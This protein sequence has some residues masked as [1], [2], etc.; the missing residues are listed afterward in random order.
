MTLLAT[1]IKAVQLS[2]RY[3]LVTSTST[4]ADN[5]MDFFINAGQTYLDKLTN[6]PE[7]FA[8]LFLPLAVDEYSLTFQHQCRAITDVWA[9]S[10]SGRYLL[11]KVSLNDLKNK[12]SEPITSVT[13]DSVAYYAI[14]N[15]RALETTDKTTLGEFINLTWTETDEKYNYRGL[16]IVP[17]ADEAMTIEI[18][19]KFLQGKLSSDNDENYWTVE[20]PHLLIMATLR[21][22]EVFN[23]NT[24]GINDWTKALM[25]EMKELQF[26]VIEEE[27]YGI[28][29]LEG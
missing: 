11:E 3:D 18:N 14:A 13:S 25:T 4:Y 24:E 26:D 9:N 21:S 10:T 5:G 19:G 12:Y 28:N 27:S 20:Y 17:P 15:L 6:T 29:Q 22:I 16:I 2:G 8:S 23:R 1:R 7:T